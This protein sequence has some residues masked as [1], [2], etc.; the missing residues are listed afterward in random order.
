MTVPVGAMVPGF[1]LDYSGVPEIDAAGVVGIGHERASTGLDPR[2]PQRLGDVD[3]LPA[4]SPIAAR[5]EAAA[6]QPDEQRALRVLRQAMHASAVEPVARGRESPPT[7][8]GAEHPPELP[9]GVDD[10]WVA[11]IDDDRAEHP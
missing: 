10:L 5:E 4:V 1:D 9:A 11:T 3:R 6:A 8:D 7:V 2:A